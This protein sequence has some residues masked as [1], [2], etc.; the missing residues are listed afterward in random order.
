MPE[1][2]KLNLSDAGTRELYYDEDM[3]GF[4]PVVRVKARY[5]MAPILITI[6]LAGVLAYITF[7]VANVQIT[8]TPF[9][10]EDLGFSGALLNGLLFTVIAGVSSV[11]IFY[12]VKYKGASALKVV[13]AISFLLLGTTLFLFFG[14]GILYLL[15]APA[16]SGWA[17]LVG[18]GVVTVAMVVI[19]FREDANV[20]ARN[21]IIVAFG[22]LIGAFMGIIMPTWTTV[23]ILAGISLWDIISVKKGPIKK[24]LE[25][26]GVLPDE[27]G[28]GGEGDEK[29]PEAGLS[30]EER[31]R[32]FKDSQLEI[33]IGD[34]AFYSVLTSHAL[35]YTGSLFTMVLTAAGIVVGCFLTINMLKKNK[36]LPGLPISIGLGILLLF[37][38]ILFKGLVA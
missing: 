32:L 11:L 25:I 19:L 34:L 29:S 33:G 31:D 1:P 17:L 23:M 26:T 8:A 3:P 16:W 14:D 35:V 30:R 4:M 38:G 27:D 12:L 7:V 2:G 20:W 5:F 36:I 9:S 13:L 6:V 21:L 37:V 24:I 22:T 18:S 15:G 28:E 10:E